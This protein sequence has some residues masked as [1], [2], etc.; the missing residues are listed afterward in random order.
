MLM[1]TAEA[2]SLH[3]RREG[4]GHQP[5]KGGRGVELVFYARGH[6]AWDSGLGVRGV[7]I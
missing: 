4:R 1:L 3:I 5:R 6:V 7:V 2:G